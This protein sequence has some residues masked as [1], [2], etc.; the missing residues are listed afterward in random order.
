MREK[1]RI[2]EGDSFHTKS[3]ARLSWLD[4]VDPALHACTRPGRPALGT[5]WGGEG[6][7]HEGF[8]TPS[9]AF[10]LPFSSLSL[11]NGIAVA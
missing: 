2:L 5:E 7:C 11:Q 9:R 6:H 4:F 8:V 3:D 10:D 1:G